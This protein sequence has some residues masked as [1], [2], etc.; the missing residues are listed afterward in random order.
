[1]AR[2]VSIHVGVNRVKAPGISV[3]DLHGCEHDASAM[4]DLARAAGFVSPPGLADKPILSEEATHQHV[5]DAIK[6]SAPLSDGDIFLFTFSG[7]GTQRPAQDITE[8]PD[9]H[10]DETIVLHDRIMIDD[11]FRKLLWPEF[12]PGVRILAISDSCHSASVFFLVNPMGANTTVKKK[13]DDQVYPVLFREVPEFQAVA[14]FQKE[15]IFFNDLRAKIAAS[16]KKI[17]AN[18]ISLG[19]CKD[20]DKTA[21]GPVHGRFTEALLNV[22]D[23]GHFVGDYNQFRANIEANLAVQQPNRNPK[24]TPVLLPKQGDIGFSQA[25]FL[26]RPF[27]I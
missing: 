11:V 23:G 21:D 7:H 4:H 5:F 8:E 9:D 6:N 19:A 2:G 13:I 16:Q 27:T 15:K 3:P 17:Q 20:N 12:N 18:L 25:F 14:H 1:M 10:E 24:Q 22:W 26:Q